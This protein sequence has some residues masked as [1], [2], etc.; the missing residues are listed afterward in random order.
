MV[1]VEET[2]R[3]HAEYLLDE[4][5]SFLFGRCQEEGFDLTSDKCA[6]T[7]ALL[8]ESYKAA[9]YKSVGIEH[10]LQ[11]VAEEFFI[12]ESKLEEQKSQET[13]IVET[14]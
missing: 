1:S 7:T 9:L 3:E 11:F 12:E 2:R 10:P 14:E 4:T 13:P 5:L 6:K 8:V